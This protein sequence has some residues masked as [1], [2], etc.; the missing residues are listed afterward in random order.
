MSK[1]RETADLSNGLDVDSSGRVLMTSQPAFFAYLNANQGIVL[2]GTDEKVLFNA[3]EYDR[4][5]N[6]SGSEFTAPVSGLYQLNVC[7]T[8]LSVSQSSRYARVTLYKNGSNT[9]IQGHTHMS[10]ETNN[11]DYTMCS[12]GATLEL[13]ANDVIS[14]YAATA[15]EDLTITGINKTTHF[16]GYLVG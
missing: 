8:F 12:Y 6:F 13:S 5:S 10:D 4:G 11:A 15:D 7:V 3:E 9:G 2:A 14:V 16:S 1:A